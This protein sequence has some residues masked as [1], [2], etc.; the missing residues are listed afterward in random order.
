M[1]KKGKIGPKPR[2]LTNAEIAIKFDLKSERTV[3]S[4]VKSRDQ[5]VF[6][7]DKIRG[8]RI[9]KRHGRK[10]NNKFPALE[11]YLNNS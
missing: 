7:V 9:K 11:A 8:K 3:R 4:F 10:K 2:T 1:E 6:S 5:G